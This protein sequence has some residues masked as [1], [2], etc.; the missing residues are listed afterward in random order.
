MLYRDLSKSFSQIVI[1]LLIVIVLTVVLTMKGKVGSGGTND[2]PISRKTAVAAT[3][4]SKAKSSR[5]KKRPP[6]DDGKTISSSTNIAH[7]SSSHK[8]NENDDDHDED[9]DHD[10]D[11]SNHK[12]APS[13]RMKRTTTPKKTKAAKQPDEPRNPQWDAKYMELKAYQKEHGHCL[14]PQR[15]SINPSLGTWVRAQRDRK[16]GQKKNVGRPLTSR[17]KQELD[18]IG[19]VWDLSA[20]TTSTTTKKKSSTTTK[21]APATRAGATSPVKGK[22]VPPAKAASA[23]S[24]RPSASAN[25]VRSKKS[26]KETG[27]SWEERYNELCAFQEI[28]GHCNPSRG[29]FV[30]LATWV[31]TQRQRKKGR[32]GLSVI[33]QEE[34]GLMEAI[35]FEW[36]PSKSRKSKGNDGDE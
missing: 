7:A 6:T 21:E 34:I 23:P 15:Y 17:E 24:R 5:G 9:D 28:Y 35:G 31:A 14:V 1:P 18:D 33:S 30:V 3:V 36:E 32:K 25:T 8:G 11:G 13:K 22:V 19:F 10:V 2:G 20:E 4:T 26:S 16:K 29:Q 27:V 12:A